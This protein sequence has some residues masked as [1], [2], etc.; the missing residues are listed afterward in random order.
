[1]FYPICERACKTFSVAVVVVKIYF[2][3]A[4][5]MKLGEKFFMVNIILEKLLPLGNLNLFSTNQPSKITL[6]L[7]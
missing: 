5:Y 2:T 4:I 7:K 1:M 3:S 6:T